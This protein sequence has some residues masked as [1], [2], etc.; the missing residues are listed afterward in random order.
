M[1]EK[2]VAIAVAAEGFD[3]SEDFLGGHRIVFYHLCHSGGRAS[4]KNKQ[5]PAGGLGPGY[6]PPAPDWATYVRSTFGSRKT[7]SFFPSTSAIKQLPLGNAA[8]SSASVKRR[9]LSGAFGTSADRQS[10]RL[11]SS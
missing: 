11:N 6:L 7:S 9:G 5:T 4:K 8:T 1:V 2:D 10:T 3:F